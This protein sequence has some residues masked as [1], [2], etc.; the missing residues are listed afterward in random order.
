MKTIKLEGFGGFGEGGQRRE[1]ALRDFISE[2][3][4]TLSVSFIT[5]SKGNYFYKVHDGYVIFDASKNNVW[6]TQSGWS[7]NKRHGRDELD[8]MFDV[9]KFAE[10]QWK[11]L[12]GLEG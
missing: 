3:L 11:R 8:D 9:K 1:N 12:N 2:K 5:S 10:R 6:Y 7:F 4:E